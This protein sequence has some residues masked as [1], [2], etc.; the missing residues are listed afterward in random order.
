MPNPS[1]KIVSA[2]P[3]LQVGDY[4]LAQTIDRGRVIS[5]MP[6]IIEGHRLEKVRIAGKEHAVGDGVGSKNACVANAVDVSWLPFAAEK[7]QISPDLSDYLL[8][9]GI[10]ILPEK[11]PNR[12][13]DAFTYDELTAWRTMGKAPAYLGFRGVPAHIDHDNQVDERAAGV[14]LDATMNRVFGVWHVLILKAIDRSKYPKLANRILQSR[15]AGIGHSMGALVEKTECSIC[16]YISDGVNTCEH[17][18][19]G[20][21]KGRIFNNV[22]TY[23]IL[24]DFQFVES[25][26][27]TTEQASPT[28]LSSSMM[29]M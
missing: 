10:P 15:G 27:I 3:G 11:F 18:A 24:R 23:E 13:G 6:K 16:H 14:V 4:C 28:A 25:S 22:L 1:R 21:G 8:L 29:E 17:I 26:V 2:G 9:P 20:A 7:Y 5:P 12:N 19:G